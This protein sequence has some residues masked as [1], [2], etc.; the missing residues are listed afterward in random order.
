[1]STATSARSNTLSTSSSLSA[2]HRLPTDA[3]RRRRLLVAPGGI[4]CAAAPRLAAVAR[5]VALAAAVVAVFAPHRERLAA[6]DAAADLF[7][8]VGI[9]ET[10]E[11]RRGLPTEV[12]GEGDDA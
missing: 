7:D 10:S 9:S 6:R 4:R 12:S 8:R 1:M 3:R 11:P 2:A 5:G